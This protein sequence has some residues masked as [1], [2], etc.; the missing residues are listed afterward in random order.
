M[1]RGCTTSH[2]CMHRV[3]RGQ[4]LSMEMVREAVE[5]AMIMRMTMKV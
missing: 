3:Q 4:N 2:M 5:R 1:D